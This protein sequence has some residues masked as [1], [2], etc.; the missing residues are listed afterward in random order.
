VIRHIVGSKPLPAEI[1]PGCKAKKQKRDRGD[2]IFFKTVV[3]VAVWDYNL[4]QGTIHV[5]PTVSR[6]RRRPMT[7]LRMDVP[8]LRPGFRLRRDFLVERDNPRDEHRRDNGY[9]C[10]SSDL[11]DH[12]RAPVFFVRIV[13]GARPAWLSLIFG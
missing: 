8:D 11:S 9:V 5:R 3:E 12:C 2:Q 1:L 13:E 4:R 10:S 7:R 6:T